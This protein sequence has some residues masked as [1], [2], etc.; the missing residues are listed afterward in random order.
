MTKLERL[1]Q[2]ARDLLKKLQDLRVLENLS[3]DQAKEMRSILDEL[4]TVQAD[5]ETEER[6]EA[7]EKRFGKAGDRKTGENS[8][9]KTDE[10]GG[11]GGDQNRGS[12]IEVEDH[13]IYRGNWT[14][15]QQMRDVFLSSSPM[16]D[17]G[18]KSEARSRLEQARRRSEER[19]QEADSREGMEFRDRESRAAG[20]GMTEGVAS[21][22][23]FL[24]QSE[25]SVDLM[26]HA[27]KSGEILRRCQSRTLS[28]A[29][30][31]AEVIMLDETSR[32]TG[33]RA[34]GIR[35][36]TAAELE[37]MTSSTTK[38]TKLQI[39]L[40]KLTGLFY[41]SDELLEDVALLEG[42]VRSLFFGPDGEFV[43]KMEDLIIRGSGAGEP[44]G[45]LNAPATVSQAKESGQAAA[46]VM[47]ENVSK[48]RSRLWARSFPRA[49]WFVN[50]ETLPQLETMKLDVGT[51]GIPVYMP[52]GGISGSP[53][54]RLYGR[55]LI[56]VEYAEA[57]GT[58]G[59]IML[60][61]FSQYMTANKGGMTSA[62]SIHL[63]FDYN[64]TVFR[65]IY[66]FDGQPRW[67]SALTPYKGSNTLSPFVTLAT[68]A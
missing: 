35:V 31:A 6:A 2:Q 10:T 57:L 51:G 13:P 59:D 68:R 56:P 67:K 25:T 60:A 11:G 39:Q 65:F 14:L 9:T 36:Y 53:Y 15:G 17:P 22:G 5:I 64:Q 21:E 8:K 58:V 44:L 49:A 27:M 63:K 42:E 62:M 30:N 37:A 7:A 19:F 40:N 55:E 24:L 26:T 28:G 46:T 61:D 38:F 16:A 33:S 50:I 54:D 23:G 29:N 18:R 32:A 1:K 12:G 3:D 43:F 47:F 34:G 52:A 41:A 20:T 4:D 48:M 45:V 66:R